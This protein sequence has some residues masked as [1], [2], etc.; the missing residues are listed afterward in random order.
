[1]SKRFV[2][3]MLVV[4]ILL[5]AVSQA[6]TLPQSDDL[7]WRYD[8]DVQPNNQDL[9][10]N[11][12]DDWFDGGAPTVSGGVAVGGVESE[13]YRT[14]FGGSIWRANV[15][16]SAF[17]IEFSVQ[18]LNTGT[19]GTAGTLGC[20]ARNPATGGGPYFNVARSGQ[21]L[22]NSQAT[23]DL[24]T[25]DNTDA[26][27]VFRI[28]REEDGSVWIWRDGELLNPDGLPLTGDLA[29]FNGDILQI[30]DIWS[31]GHSGDYEL[32]YVALDS[33]AYAPE[34]GLFQW[35]YDMD[36]QPNNQDLD[37]NGIDDW[38]D[39]GA[40]AV[41]DGVALGGVES[42]FFRNDFDGSIWRNNIQG[43]EFTVEFSVQILNGGT[44]GT[45]GTMGCYVRNPAAAGG[46]YF[47]IAR[48]GQT[49]IDSTGSIQ[50]G[51]HDNTDGQHIFRIT[52]ESDG[53]VWVW[54]D[55]ELLNPNAQPL[56]GDKAITY[57]NL[58]KIG[59]IWSSGLSGEY[60]LDYIALTDQSVVQGD[61][62]PQQIV[63]QDDFEAYDVD[64]P[65]DFS[66]NDQPTGNWQA[67]PSIADSSRIFD[68]GNFGGTRLWI[69]HVDGTELMSKPL[70]VDPA[71]DYK[72]SA[73]IMSETSS[74]TSQL[75]VS[76]DILIGEDP[77]TATSAISGPVQIVT[78][79]DDAD[80]ADSKQDHIFEHEFTTPITSS[81]D[82]LYIVINRIGV[83]Q[84]GAWLG[85]DDVQLEKY[86][87]IYIEE[88]D[89]TTQV[90]EAGVTDS[91]EINLAYAPVA[92]IT[93]TATPDAQLDLGN[94]AGQPITLTFTPDGALTQTVTVSA[95]DDNVSEGPQNAEITHT[96]DSTDAEFVA[97]R[98]VSVLID[99]DERYCGDEH[100]V[101][102]AGDL[103]KDCYLT[104]D[105]LAIFAEDWLECSDPVNDDC[106]ANIPIEPLRQTDVYVSGQD[107]INT[108]RIPSLIT[109]PDGTLLA[110]CEARKYSSRDKSPSMMVVKRS[111]D[112]G[113]T[114]GPM[115]IL[116][117]AGQHAAMDPMPVVDES[118]GR[119]WLLYE[120]WPE[121]WDSN[122]Q[123]GLTT[124][125]STTIWAQY[126]DDNGETWSGPTDITEQ[127]KKPEWEYYANGPGRA[128]Q[129]VG[130]SHPGRMIVAC[131]HNG[132]T[133]GT[134]HYYY[135][136]DHGQTWQLGDGYLN[137]GSE[138]QMVELIDGTLLWNIRGGGA[139]GRRISYSY[140][141]G[142]TWTSV[143]N[144]PALIEPGG[145]Q[146]S[147][148]RYT[149]TDQGYNQNRILFSNPAST[150]SRVNMTVKMSYDECDTWPVAKQIYGGSS[151][152]SCL[153]ILDDGSIGLLYEADGYGRIRFAR[154]TL[155][156]LTDGE[157]WLGKP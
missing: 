104:I 68:T 61:S 144:D 100:T 50:L 138:S 39:A 15:T 132:G 66:V 120:L 59:D 143:T 8:M 47:T 53:S 25:Q 56:I 52:R 49:Y 4:T 129:T 142:Q 5:C 147:L 38:A 44:E 23:L 102:L 125:P 154:F 108:Y 55:G 76:Y 18:V 64:N 36:V 156:W 30:G 24:G 54:R 133:D 40:P 150:S 141:D 10:L 157:D 105:D 126:T 135:S 131:S 153:T 42:E 28:A 62:A 65:T 121:G 94:G 151:A 97:L 98:A 128:I 35:V 155:R 3:S 111:F 123:P 79:G 73:A 115:E 19:E 48:T 84:V 118:N 41:S 21:S 71:T 85:V 12:V 145:C 149:R 119:L 32:D 93:V 130:G 127:V 136:D 69:S 134:Q 140:D 16:G 116:H 33:A 124:P 45:A 81:A 107:N 114:W 27:H 74:G 88:T 137:T 26:Q 146:A 109:A 148:L 139:A 83:N 70:P 99:D 95:V 117:D 86:P 31:S 72:F 1:M 96:V 13:Y 90:E 80:I 20:Y 67:D 63:F 22:I 14:D 17:T 82:N 87:T 103:N 7:A 2:L 6:V 92:D 9:D 46:P 113:L 106:I 77:A 43:M 152:Y 37:G 101:Y 89:E 51:T 34:P 75:D 78:T 91:Y 60:E 110:F 57:Y 58:V 112:N 11:G 29:V 122:P